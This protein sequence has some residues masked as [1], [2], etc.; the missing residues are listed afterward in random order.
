MPR[1]L[2]IFDLSALP[3][4][5]SVATGAPPDPSAIDFQAFAHCGI[6]RGFAASAATSALAST[7]K[8]STST[9]TE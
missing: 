4:H 8:H 2:Q 9:S 1:L 7:L 5:P 3:V 6:P